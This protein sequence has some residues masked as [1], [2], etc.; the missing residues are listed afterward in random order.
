MNENERND[1]TNPDTAAAASDAG[2]SRVTR[3]RGLSRPALIGIGAGVGMAGFMGAFALG[4]TA[5]WGVGRG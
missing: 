5:G 1:Q 4:E 3:R 2:A